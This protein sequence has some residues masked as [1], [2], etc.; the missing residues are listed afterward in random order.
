ML[1]PMSTLKASSGVNAT[2]LAP[3]PPDLNMWRTGASEWVSE[4]VSE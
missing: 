4:W 3:P 2:F 1:F